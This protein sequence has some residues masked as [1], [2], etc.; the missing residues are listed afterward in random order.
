MKDSILE[1]EQLKVWETTTGRALVAGSSFRVRRGECLA[2]VGESGSGKSLTCRALMR[3]PQPGIAQSGS[4]VLNGSELSSL[5]EKEMRRTRGKRICLIMQNGMRA[6]D[7]SRPVGAHLQETLRLHQSWSREQSEDR[8]RQAFESVGLAQPASIWKRY[9]HELSGGMLQ[10]VMIALAIVMKP[11]LLIA[12]EPTTAL[13]ASTQYEVVEQFARLRDRMGVSMLFVSHDL[14]V[15]KRLA[16]EVLVMRQG[17]IV[18]R[19]RANALFAAPQ[20]PYTRYLVAA[21]AELKRSFNR[22]MGGGDDTEGL[23]REQVL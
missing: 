6:F 15:I 7:P 5:T 3:L 11:D 20:H 23:R 19:G 16:D 4:I 10:R 12:D 8:L 14:S 21:K 18:E 9:P 1:V 13:D 22:L 17:E 2:I